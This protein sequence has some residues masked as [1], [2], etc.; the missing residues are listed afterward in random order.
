MAA[1]DPKS[2]DPLLGIAFSHHNLG[3]ALEN[4][5]RRAEALQEYRLARPAYEAVLAMSPSAAW[6][7]GMLATL[8]VETADLQYSED[9]A[10]AC[11][12]YGKAVGIFES[13]PGSELGQN[14]AVPPRARERL[15][16]CR[17]RP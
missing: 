4:L 9:R 10:S 12:L 13:V 11:E 3:E 5:G 7:A 15:A 8:Y 16:A 14:K 2:T 1:E 17:S 6:A